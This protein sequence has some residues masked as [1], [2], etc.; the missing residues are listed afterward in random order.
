MKEVGNEQGRQAGR[1]EDEYNGSKKR[2]IQDWREN[3]G[4]N[5]KDENIGTDR[6]RK[7]RWIQR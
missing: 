7:R 3:D 4:R 5:R 6:E 2:R 1:G